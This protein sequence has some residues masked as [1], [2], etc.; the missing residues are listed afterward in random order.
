M[1]DK[2]SDIAPILIAVIFIIIIWRFF[3]FSFKDTQNHIVAD[4][5]KFVDDDTEK[6]TKYDHNDN[7][8]DKADSDTPMKEPD[9]IK[10]PRSTI[11]RQPFP[12]GEPA[13]PFPNGGPTL[14]FP[15]EEHDLHSSNPTFLTQE[16]IQFRYGDRLPFSNPPPPNGPA[17]AGGYGP[18]EVPVPTGYMAE[19]E[20]IEN[21]FPEFVRL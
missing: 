21:V 4:E 5:I 17:F 20:T 12:V 6:T 15:G 10:V 19:D 16:D 1:F 13:L 2:T 14:P 18:P 11:I 8:D 3:V 9:L 7:E